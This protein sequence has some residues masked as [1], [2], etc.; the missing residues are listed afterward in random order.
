M[1][2]RRGVRSCGSASILPPCGFLLVFYF[3]AVDNVPPWRLFSVYFP[4]VGIG[5]PWCLFSAVGVCWLSIAV[6]L[7]LVRRGVYSP[8]WVSASI[9]PPCGVC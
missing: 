3:P 9:L 8:P 1:F 6:R 2:I 7:I 5:P 4:A